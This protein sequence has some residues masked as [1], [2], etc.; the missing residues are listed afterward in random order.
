MSMKSDAARA[1][2]PKGAPTRRAS[3]GSGAVAQQASTAPRTAPK[4]R[5]DEASLINRLTQPR[6]PNSRYIAM[7][8]VAQVPATQRRA[9][10]PTLRE[11]PAPSL[12]ASMDSAMRRPALKRANT[13]GGTRSM[14]ITPPRLQPGKAAVAGKL[15][16]APAQSATGPPEGHPARAPPSD[17]GLTGAAKPAP[18]AASGSAPATATDA[19]STSEIEEMAQAKLRSLAA[20]LERM[21][22]LEQKTM[23][24][25]EKTEIGLGLWV[26]ARAAHP[27]LQAPV[28]LP[29][30]D[31]PAPPL[32]HNPPQAAG[33]EV[34]AVAAAAAAAHIEPPQLPMRR[35]EAPVPPVPQAAP[36]AAAVPPGAAAAAVGS[37][38][39]AADAAAHVGP[40][41]PPVRREEAYAPPVPQGTPQAGAATSAATARADAAPT[42]SPAKLSIAEMTAQLAE[43]RAQQRLIASR[44]GVTSADA[45][46]V[47]SSVSTLGDHH[48]S[49]CP[50]VQ[51]EVRL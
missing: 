42:A 37:G 39:A 31:A 41:Q 44:L 6:K 3:V 16:G 29:R 26:K 2:G 22:I 7:A 51:L 48:S 10:D 36:Q 15:E 4:L 46:A 5:V 45:S 28:P 30:Q 1:N 40:P 27:V 49:S 18:A 33:A 25:L 14:A 32:P 17:Q 24:E 20:E 8:P 23:E 43:M 50:G 21:R 19:R 47:G 34:G 13:G 38:A 11:R 35:Q 12:A 9:S